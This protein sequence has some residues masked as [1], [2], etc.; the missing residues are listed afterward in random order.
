LDHDERP[1]VAHSR[2]T[3]AEVCPKFTII[4]SKPTN[5]SIGALDNGL[6]Y[7]VHTTD[8]SPVTDKWRYYRV[9]DRVFTFLFGLPFVWILPEIAKYLF[10]EGRNVHIS[11]KLLKKFV[12]MR[13]MLWYFHK[14]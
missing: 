9:A 7:F 13:R 6:R 1:D 4:G 12:E 5:I 2:H 11:A 10:Q 14:M 3:H 8:A